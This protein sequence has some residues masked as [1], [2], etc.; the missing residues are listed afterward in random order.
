MVWLWA[1]CTIM[2]PASTSPRVTG[3]GE[4]RTRGSSYEDT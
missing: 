2:G 1:T 3:S 4:L